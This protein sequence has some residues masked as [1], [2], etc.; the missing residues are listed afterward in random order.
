MSGWIEKII[1]RLV[2]QSLWR[3]TQIAQ[4]KLKADRWVKKYNLCESAK[5]ADCFEPAPSASR[6]PAD[7]KAT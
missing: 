3:T 4:I 7:A 2:R 5:S 6:I 1:R